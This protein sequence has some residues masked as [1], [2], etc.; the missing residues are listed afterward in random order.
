M[1]LANDQRDASRGAWQCIELLRNWAVFGLVAAFGLLSGCPFAPPPARCSKD[2]DCDSDGTPYCLVEGDMSGECVECSNNGHCD[3][4]L[5]CDGDESCADNVCRAGTLPC[6]PE[7]CDEEADVC[8]EPCFGDEDCDDGDFC[9]GAEA[10]G[11]DGRCQA[12]IAPCDVNEVCLEGTGCV[13]CVTSLDCAGGEECV[14]FACEAVALIVTLDGCPEDIFIEREF[15]LW[16]A[17]TGESDDVTFT[18]TG[19]TNVAITGDDDADPD[20]VRV[21]AIGSPLFAEITVTVQRIRDAMP[22]GDPTTATC[23]PFTTIFEHGPVVSAGADQ[24]ATAVFAVGTPL[25]FGTAGI[26]LLEAVA[27]DY[28]AEPGDTLQY[29]WRVV[30]TPD[31]TSQPLETVA[32]LQPLSAGDG[33]TSVDVQIDPAGVATVLNLLKRDGSVTTHSNTVVP[34]PY[35]FGVSVTTVRGLTVYDTVVRT[36]VPQWQPQVS[37]DGNLA[38]LAATGGIYNN[39]MTPAGGANVDFESLSRVGG[40]IDFTFV[41]SDVPT[42]IADLSSETVTASDTISTLMVPFPAS[43]RGTFAIH[44]GL[45]AGQVSVASAA[46]GGR[47][48]VGTDLASTTVNTELPITANQIGQPQSTSGGRLYSGV[49]NDTVGGAANTANSETLRG[50]GILFA[51]IKNDGNDHLIAWGAADANANYDAQDIR[52]YKPI[53]NQAGNANTLGFANAN[54]TFLEQI[55]TGCTVTDVAIGPLRGDS[56]HPELVVACNAGDPLAKVYDHNGATGANDKVY[57]VQSNQTTAA[58]PSTITFDYT[59]SNTALLPPQVALAPFTSTSYNDLIFGDAGFDSG[60]DGFI[61]GKV[62]I[63]RGGTAGSIPSP[64]FSISTGAAF[65]NLPSNKWDSYTGVA[66]DANDEPFFGFALATAPF[67][68]T[69]LHDIYVGAPGNDAAVANAVDIT[70]SVFRIPGGSALNSTDA[71]SNV[72]AVAWSGEVFGDQFG[73]GVVTTP[74]GQIVIAATQNGH[75]ANSANGPG[76]VYV[77]PAAAANAVNAATIP[78][79]AGVQASDFFGI[80]MA[81]GVFEGADMLVAASPTGNYFKLIPT[82]DTLSNPIIPMTKVTINAIDTT[83]TIIIGD[84]NGDGKNDVV[85]SRSGADLVTALWGRQ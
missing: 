45:N 63:L 37:D 15:T 51:D 35:E 23:G 10:C 16:A 40:L 81:T 8:S 42:S 1:V 43:A 41:D 83:S 79:V 85:V 34:G 5:F 56:T 55:D 52:I 65:A 9:N 39:V 3:N 24:S 33:V 58:A 62:I 12:G 48:L 59:N 11:S 76:K 50:Q 6:G 67:T 32:I 84:F 20:V 38:G 53:N 82:G 49:A 28:D 68:S 78:S 46:T 77:Y 25:V 69:T 13:E 47:V 36:I 70:G 74:A 57:S 21:A 4:G 72:L 26:P 2:A 7:T 17:V 31:T 80:R 27:A 18:W 71:T 44:A 54:F 30:A 14:S 64:G 22:I 19:T 61:E 60:A 73:F 75:T 29:E 66:T